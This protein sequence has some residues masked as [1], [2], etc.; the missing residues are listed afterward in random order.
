MQKIS[1]SE[2]AHS[3]S[4]QHTTREPKVRHDITYK[5][6]IGVMWVVEGDRAYD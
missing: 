2:H 1:C 3:A 4:L 6:A 5:M